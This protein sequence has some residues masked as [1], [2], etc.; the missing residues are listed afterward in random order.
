SR[1]AGRKALCRGSTMQSAHAQTAPGLGAARRSSIAAI[2][3]NTN[4][5]YC[6]EGYG[7]GPARSIVQTFPRFD[8]LCEGWGHTRLGVRQWNKR[9]ASWI[10]SLTIPP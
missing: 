8:E 7:R 2:D 10:L 5:G 4:V 1:K 9:S 3:A 6:R